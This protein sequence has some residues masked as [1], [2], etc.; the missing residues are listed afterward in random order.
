[1]VEPNFENEEQILGYVAANVVSKINDIEFIE[2]TI[3]VEYIN[4]LLNE[5]D[6][7]ETLSN[8][9]I[10]PDDYS[11][12]DDVTQSFAETMNDNINAFSKSFRKDG[13]S[14]AINLYQEKRKLINRQTIFK[15]MDDYVHKS[16][17]VA[18]TNTGDLF[19]L[20]IEKQFATIIPGDL[21][22]TEK[23]WWMF[24]NYVKNF[25]SPSFIT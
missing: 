10:L 17:E 15:R 23:F 19:K 21:S 12:F 18:K 4:N 5:K 16:Y 8:Y 1:M 20:L 7:D 9:M 6:W 13:F 14:G 11:H 25:I 3:E 2:I 24:L 22:A